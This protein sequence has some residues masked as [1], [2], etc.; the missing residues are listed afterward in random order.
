M[1]MLQ[2]IWNDI[3]QGENVDL[4]LTVLVALAL[5]GMNI[6]GWAPDSW[7]APITLAVLALLAVSSL[8]NRHRLERVLQAESTENLFLEEY[9]PDLRGDIRRA[10]ELW[11]VGVSLTSTVTV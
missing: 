6:A 10:E 4:Y 7:L 8:G 5:V 9:P 3:R 11:L 1:R 2:Q